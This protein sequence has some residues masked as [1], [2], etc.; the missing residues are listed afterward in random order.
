MKSAQLCLP[1]LC[2]FTLLVLPARGQNLPNE[3]FEGWTPSGRPAP[4]NWEEPTGWKTNNA[5][6][7]FTSAG[8]RK[9]PMSRTGTYAAWIRTVNVFGEFVPG[10]TANGE[11][12]LNFS[13][14]SLNPI[15]G[16][17]PVTGRPSALTGFYRFTSTSAGDSALAMIILKK[18]NPSTESWDV[19]GGGQLALAPV[20][21]YRMFEIPV[22]YQSDVVAD[23]VVVAF[24]S[25]SPLNPMEGG[26]L[27]VDDIAL[28]F[29]LGVGDDRNLNIVVD[30]APNP[31]ID[32]LQIDFPERPAQPT[33]I[34]FHDML[35]RTVLQEELTDRSTSIA[36]DLPEG[37]YLYRIT[38]GEGE[39]VTGRVIVNHRR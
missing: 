14:Y 11:P 12:E 8:V 2:L 27:F 25:T 13:T 19:V 29:G 34:T 31:V 9:S 20:D 35:G 38:Q 28:S 30:L 10:M 33:L 21:E 1:L 7:E 17:T 23:S 3:S 26:E 36:V 4:F 18:Y 39:P 22:V 16:G 6:T 37:A 32:R 5:A 15:T 24:M